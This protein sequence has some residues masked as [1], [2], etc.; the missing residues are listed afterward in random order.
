MAVLPARAQDLLTPVVAAPLVSS[1]LAVLCMS[2]VI[3]NTGT[4]TAML[5][6]IEVVGASVLM[7]DGAALLT[8]RMLPVENRSYRLT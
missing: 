4:A 5:Q 3:P 8:L 2:W 1:T 6:T 7:F